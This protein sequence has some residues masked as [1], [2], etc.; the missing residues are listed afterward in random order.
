[1]KVPAVLLGLVAVSLAALAKEPGIDAFTGF[2]MT[3]DWELVRANCIACHSPKLV[4]QQRGTAEQW[5]SMIR[6][7]QEK[8]N[9]WEFEPDV[10]RRIVAY[11]AEQFPPSADRRRA[12]IPPALMPPN[13]YAPDTTKPD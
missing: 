3:G 2:P 7:M 11:L 13:P 1:M 10:E 12:A 9:L 8:Q 6:W 4:T 5:L